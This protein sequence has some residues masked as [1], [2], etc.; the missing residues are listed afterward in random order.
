MQNVQSWYPFVSKESQA[1]VSKTD[2]MRF[3][4]SENLDKESLSSPGKAN[5]MTEYSSNQHNGFIF[6]KSE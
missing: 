1:Y 4:K 2:I 6:W 3:D 5:I